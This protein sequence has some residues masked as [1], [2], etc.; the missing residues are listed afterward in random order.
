MIAQFTLIPLGTKTDSLSQSLVNAMKLV[1]ESGLAYKAGPMGTAVE[2]DW[3]EVMDLIGRCR[4]A[5]LKEAPRVM[6]L[7]EVDDRKGAKNP[8]VSKLASL[9]KKMGIKLK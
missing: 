5:I 2:G 1:A 8:I 6:V 3:D 7:I 9:E 4:E